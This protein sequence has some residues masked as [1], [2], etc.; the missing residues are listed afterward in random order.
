[1][2]EERLGLVCDNF[3]QLE[4]ETTVAD[5]LLTSEEVAI[6]VILVDRWPLSLV[7]IR[8]FNL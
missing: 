1:M 4:R 3:A 6:E 7:L 5:V 2:K 8:C